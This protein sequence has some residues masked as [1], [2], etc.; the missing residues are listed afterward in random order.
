MTDEH[1]LANQELAA[2][3]V[4]ALDPAEVSGLEAHLRTC[5]ICQADLGAYR[6]VSSGLLSAVPPVY[7]RPA[8]R[9]LL[10]RRLTHQTQPARSAWRWSPWQLASAGALALIIVLGIVSSLQLRSLLESQAELRSRSDSQQIAVAML[11]YPSTQSIGFAQNGISG[12]LLV[13]KQRGLIAVFAWHL[14]VP[15]AGKTYQMWLIDPQGHRTS[16]GLLA[17][18]TGYPFVTAVIT[19]PSPLSNFNGLGVTV[20]PL[21]GS[22]AP[23]GPRIFGVDF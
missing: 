15:P 23:T 20:E 9:Q 21:G 5:K 12:S 19:S 10:Q 14:P 13:D 18:E 11:A 16:G 7:P 17:Y 3:A 4:D 22:P 8:V 2:Y 1:A 6:R